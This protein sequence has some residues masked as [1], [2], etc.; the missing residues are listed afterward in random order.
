MVT[1]ETFSG[2]LNEPNEIGLLTPWE[3]DFRQIGVGSGQTPVTIRSGPVLSALSLHMDC[4][5]HQVGTSPEAMV[6]FGVPLSQ[7][8]CGWMGARVPEDFVLCFGSGH[9]F[10]GVTEKG[11]R[12][13]TLSLRQTDFEM[14]AE[15]FGLDVPDHAFVPEILDLTARKRLFRMMSSQAA[16]YAD[17]REPE[18]DLGTDE[19]LVLSMLLATSSARVL[20]SA[21]NENER[22]K[23]L[24]RAMEII[25]AESEDPITVRDLCKRCQTSWSTLHR[26]FTD[27]FG[28]GPKRYLMA[29]RLCRV[30]ADLLNAAPGMR[31]ADAA[32]RW[33]FWHMGQFAR[34]YQKVFTRRPSED[35]R[36]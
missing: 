17:A 34:D 35:L 30:R 4:R 27:R 32:N 28:I 11:F 3:L 10:D 26:A 18:A 22:N 12:A 25:E 13:V 15:D 16:R 19:E 6:T 31:V 1:T 5:V 20:G 8:L 14:L 9:E 7:S 36:S 24:R 23:V 21:G 2:Q 33:G 29:L